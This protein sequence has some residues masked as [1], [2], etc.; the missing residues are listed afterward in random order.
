M[1]FTKVRTLVLLFF[2]FP[3]YA[4]TAQTISQ[5]EFFFDIDPGPGNGTPLVVSSPADSVIIT[6]T[7]ATT[8]LPRG[9]HIL[10]IRTRTSTGFW[11]LYEGQEFYIKE[12]IVQAEYFFDTDPGVGNGVSISVGTVSDS[13]NFTATAST[14]G[15]T[16]GEHKIAV[17]T[18]DPK[19]LWSLYETQGFFIKPSI[20][21]A[22]FFIDTDPGLGNGTPIVVTPAVDSISFSKVV[23][24]PVLPFGTHFL[25]VRTK[26]TFGKWSLYES[27]QFTVGTPLPIELISFDAIKIDE[28]EV[29]TS[30]QTASEINNDYFTVEKSANGFDF[31]PFA[32]VNGAGNSNT[33]LSY[34]AID[35]SP[36][37]NISYY[38]L[39]QTDFD[40]NF[41]YSKVVAVKFID[42]DLYFILYPN[43]N[44]GSFDISCDWK[45]YTMVE[46]KIIDNMGQ[47][48]YKT[49][50]EVTPGQNRWQV[51]APTLRNGLYLIQ[52]KIADNYG[53][54]KFLI[55]K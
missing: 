48:A 47:L 29:K 2:V 9:T 17:R 11:S 13:V 44:N 20:I 42:Q 49:T 30:W 34:E 14:T 26:D 5:A 53:R 52:L 54:H 28:G 43:P 33:I 4:L 39:K 25:F 50:F 41:T 51:N 19:G 27:Q 18:K 15:L 36:Y 6:S 40:G 7:I 23:T 46:V 38:R 12:A 35:I 10:F 55:D 3:V 32:T 1:F 16:P 8:G 45:K 37:E 21:S 31:I 24:T 22:E